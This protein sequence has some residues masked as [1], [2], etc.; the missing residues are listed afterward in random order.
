[1]A[2]SCCFNIGFHVLLDEAFGLCLSFARAL[3]SHFFWTG[4][5]ACTWLASMVNTHSEGK[6]SAFKGNEAETDIANNS[7]TN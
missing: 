2:T 5:G 4:L 7:R 3:L 6:G 1:M